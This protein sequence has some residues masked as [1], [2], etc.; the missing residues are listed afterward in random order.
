MTRRISPFL[1]SYVRAS[2]ICQAQAS[3]RGHSSV[4]FKE[5]KVRA[6]GHNRKWPSSWHFYITSL[7]TDTSEAGSLPAQPMELTASTCPTDCVP[8]HGVHDEIELS[9]IHGHI[10]PGFQQLIHNA[11]DRLHEVPLHVLEDTGRLACTW[12]SRKREQLATCPNK[13]HLSVRS[14]LGSGTHKA[15]PRST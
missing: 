15:P 4:L 6:H 7:K 10:D 5:V 2:K 9:I 13:G 1:S 11:D 14:I 8:T 3:L 12:G